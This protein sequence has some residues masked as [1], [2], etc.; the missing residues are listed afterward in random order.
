VRGGID[1]TRHTGRPAD[2]RQQFWI[3]RAIVTT[4]A[5]WPEITALGRTVWSRYVLSSNA[6]GAADEDDVH[7][8]PIHLARLNL[9]APAR[10]G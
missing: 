9:M 6:G 8:H 5:T 4:H 3:V 1:R 10:S 7:A 2:H